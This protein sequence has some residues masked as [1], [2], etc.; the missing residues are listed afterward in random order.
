M[1][2]KNIPFGSSLRTLDDDK[3]IASETSLAIRSIA[4][5]HAVATNLGPS[6]GISRQNL[7]LEKRTQIPW[8]AKTNKTVRYFRR[9]SSQGCSA[10]VRESGSFH[11]ET[12]WFGSDDG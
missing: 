4:I 7:P 1:K 6:L 9:G 10:A 11:P 3:L 5:N 2:W 12:R 8:A